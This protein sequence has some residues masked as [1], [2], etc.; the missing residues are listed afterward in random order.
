MTRPPPTDPGPPPDA[1]A[2]RKRLRNSAFAY[3]GRYAST[4]E[5]L[6][7]VLAR[8]ARRIEG[9]EAE[10]ARAAID[11]AVAFCVE[12]GLVDDAAFA[13]MTVAAGKRKGLSRARIGQRLAA[14]GVPAELARDALP[15]GDDLAGAVR[16]ARRKRLGPWRTRAVD[17]ALEKDAASLARAGYPPALARRVARLS[18]EEAEAIL[19]G[20]EDG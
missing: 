11:E 7:R 9:V 3:V 17:N 14:K 12:N 2:L 10:A 4:A 15:A 1:A 13:A 8:K 6:R 19:E 18:R 16:L 20:G 5:N